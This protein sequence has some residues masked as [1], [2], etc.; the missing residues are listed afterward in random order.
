MFEIHLVDDEFENGLETTPV[1][2]MQKV[3][4]FSYTIFKSFWAL[5]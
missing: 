5:D 4:N 3:I 2:S 1:K